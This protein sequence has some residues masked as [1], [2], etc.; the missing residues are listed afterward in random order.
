MRTHGVLQCSMKLYSIL[1]CDCSQYML[2]QHLPLFPSP[3]SSPLP[4]LPS[5]L[6]PPSPPF[7]PLPSPSLPSLLSR[8]KEA[9]FPGKYGVPRPFYFLCLPSF[10]LGRPLRAKVK[11]VADSEVRNG[12]VYCASRTHR[13]TQH[14]WQLWWCALEFL[15]GH[16]KVWLCVWGGG[17]H[18]CACS[19]TVVGYTEPLPMFSPP[20]LPHPPNLGADGVR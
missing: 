6:S 13:C 20:S 1:F 17:E 8:Y 14:W 3:P 4:P 7:L 10:W 12:P 18:A 19:L 16:S 15:W 11:A 9:V 5:L 2:S